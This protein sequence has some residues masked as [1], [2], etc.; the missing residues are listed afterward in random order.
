[1]KKLLFVL[2]FFLVVDV[3]ASS[4]LYNLIKDAPYNLAYGIELKDQRPFNDFSTLYS[5]KVLPYYTLSTDYPILSDHM[6][7]WWYKTDFAADPFDGRIEVLVMGEPLP[8]AWITFL[9][10]TAVGL[11]LYKRKQCTETLSTE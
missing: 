5:A 9:I 2:F 8:P 1:M 6:C 4:E 10:A 3:M 7:D 11:L